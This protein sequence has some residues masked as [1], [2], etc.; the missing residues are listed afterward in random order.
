[1]REEP[2]CNLQAYDELSSLLIETGFNVTDVILE[3]AYKNDHEM[4]IIGRKS[5]KVLSRYKYA[6]RNIY[7]TAVKPV[8]NLAF[9]SDMYPR[10]SNATEILFP[11]RKFSGFRRSNM[12]K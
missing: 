8:E 7:L 3:N 6:K 4:Q 12:K 1:M 9:S 2:H 11:K 10:Y 5:Y